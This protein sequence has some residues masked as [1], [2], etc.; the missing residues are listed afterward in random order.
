[1]N[2]QNLIIYEFNSLYNILEELNLNINFKILEASNE[3][4]LDDYIKK[5]NNYLILTNKKNLKYDHQILIENLPLNISKLVEKINIEF[6]KLQFNSQSKMNIKG[7][8]IDFNS[9]EM[10]LNDKKLKLTEKEVNMIIYLSKNNK[11][12]SV[13][14]LEKNVWSY[15]SDMETHTV[16]THIYRLRKKIISIFNDQNFITSQ[17]NGYEIK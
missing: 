17:K 12:V 5:F 11:S 6:L 2:N 1:M 9:R 14:E 4:S 15:N 8:T 13:N 7:Y 3:R 16:E 10:I